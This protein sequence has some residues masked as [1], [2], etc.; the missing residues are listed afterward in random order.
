MALA[1]GV[2]LGSAAQAQTII[3]SGST[4][5]NLNPANNPFQILNGSTIATVTG[6]GVHGS[7]ATPWTLTNY[8]V[9]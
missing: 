3:P 9:V 2:S 7:N 4:T 6:D 5:Y 8:G 1:A